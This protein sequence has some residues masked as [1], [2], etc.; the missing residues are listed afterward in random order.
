M[1]MPRSFIKNSYNVTCL[2]HSLKTTATV[3]SQSA[4]YIE[5]LVILCD[6][7]LD[8]NTLIFSVLYSLIQAMGSGGGKIKIVKQREHRA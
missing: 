1:C 3:K 6:I 7:E 5:I 2:P 4:D 8:I